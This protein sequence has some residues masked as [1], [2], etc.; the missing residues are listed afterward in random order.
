MNGKILGGTVEIKDRKRAV[1]Y[2][3]VK[4]SQTDDDEFCGMCSSASVVPRN[5]GIVSSVV[6]ADRFQS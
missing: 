5:T 2:L 3:K 4:S 6:G 1:S